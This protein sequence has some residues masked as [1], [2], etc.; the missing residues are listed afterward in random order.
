M[1]NISKVI[2][3]INLT[4]GY[5]ISRILKGGWQLAGGHGAIDK[6]QAVGDMFKF[7]EAGITT[8]DFGDIYI[9]VEE[10][11]GQFIKEYTNQ[12]GKARIND[13]QLNTKLVPDVDILPT[14]SKQYVEK[15]IDR[16]LR[17][18]GVESLDLVQFHWWDYDIKRYLQ[19]AYYLVDM[20][21][22]GKIR[23]IGVTNLD[24]PRLAELV[25]NRI[26]IVSN[27]VQYSVLDHRPENGMVA[28][29]Q[30][31]NIKLLC[32]GT[33]AGGFMSSRYLNVR[34][35]IP[36]YEN[37]SLTKY[38]LIIDEFGGW[39]LFQELLSVLNRIAK[40]HNVS[41]T[42]VA[43]RYV[44]DKPQ[45][46]GIIIGARN[47]DHLEANKKVF[48]FNLDQEDKKSIQVV[49]NK[50]T[51]PKGDTYFL[52]RIKN[53]KHASIMKYNLNKER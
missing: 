23:Y 19:V 28:F 37:R 6:K 17:R 51:G 11:V 24:V 20:Q 3:K 8:F 44:L 47:I 36:P 13:I 29:C 38:K 7:A 39:G 52:E 27:Q 15:I 21:T 49:V 32:Y 1:Y 22:K 35:Q 53:G 43:S 31:H 41:I 25:E 2:S 16:S 26:P 45:V 5:K 46:A 48:E 42:N 9:G 30:Q 14:I 10:L 50:S 40:K 34:E 18:L 33:A 4:K 12:F